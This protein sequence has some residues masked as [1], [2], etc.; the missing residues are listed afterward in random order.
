VSHRRLIAVGSFAALLRAAAASAQTPCPCPPPPEPPPPLWF[1]NAEI[2]Y[3][4]TSGNTDT[5]SFG[6]A[7]EVNYKPSPWLF[8][9]KA[10]YIRASSDSILTAE[11]FAGGMKASR[12]LTPRLDVFAGAL[13]YRNTFAGIASRYGGEVGAG[14][15]VINE[16]ALW[17]RLQAGFGYAHE[18]PVDAF[19][20]INPAFSY[21][22]AQ[23][24]FDFGWKFSK[25]AAVTEVFSFTDNLDNTND[26]YLR[27]TTA[28]TASLTSIF[29]L[30]ASF[31]YLY[32]NEP[33]IRIPAYDQTDTITAIGLV[34]KF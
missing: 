13:Y 24:G 3:A 10:A 4:G 26:W 23:A 9:L 32:D 16:K 27:S 22:T 33:P 6:G 29:A 30:K 25:N 14:Y 7:M 11:T 5:S 34:A 17:L 2:S 21:A 19:P 12:E 18:D 1:G 28:I 31:T 20:A 8:A 15:K